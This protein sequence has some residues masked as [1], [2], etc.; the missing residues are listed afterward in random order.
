M[1]GRLSLA[2]FLLLLFNPLS[3]LARDLTSQELTVTRAG[4]EL[5]AF[6][7]PSNSMTNTDMLFSPSVSRRFYEIAYEMAHSDVKGPELEQAIMFLM[8]AMKLDNNA[9]AVRPLLIELASRDIERD[10]SS[11]VYNLLL[12]Y[13]DEFADLEIVQ[14]GVN[15]LL[16]RLDSREER[17]QMLE[18]MMGTIAN[19]NTVVGSELATLLGILKA[20]KPDLEAAEFYLVQAYKNNR[21]NKLAFAKLAELAPEQIEPALYLERLRLALRENPVN[22]EAAIAFAQRAEELQ[23]YDTAASAY[24][25]CADLFSYLYPSEILPARIYLPWMISCYNTQTSQSKCVQIAARIRQTGRFD[26]RMEAI[27]GRAAVKVGDGQLATQIIQDAEQKARKILMRNQEPN[28]DNAAES[29]GG[30][31]QVDAAQ[32]A[33]FYCFVIPIPDRALDWANKAF[34]AEQ[35]SPM[36]A[37]LLAYALVMNNEIETAKPL[38]KRFE[39]NQIS[40]LTLAIIQLAE[41]QNAQAIESLQTAISRDPGSFAAER[42]K[43]ILSQQGR[44]Y[45]PPI[46]PAS[47]LTVLQNNFGQSLVPDFIPPEQIVS[48][49]FNIRGD[50][51]TYG[52]D[53]EGVVAVVNNSPEPL[54]VDDNGLFKGNIRIDVEISGDLGKRIPNLISKR[55][56]TTLLI[57]PG[58]RMLIPVSLATGEL[59][60][61]LLSHP[62]ASLNLQFTAYLD[63]VRT[64]DGGIVNR[65]TYIAPVQVRVQRPGVQLTSDY[66]RNQFTLVSEGQT[67]QK[68]QAARLFTGL[69]LEQHIMSDRRLAYKYVYAD[70]MPKLL[71]DALTHESGLLLNSA[72]GQWV[73]KIQ[74]MADM[75][76]L[77]LGH[78][79]IKAVA[80]NLYANEWAVRMM[81]VY[82]L[83]KNPHNGFD[84]VLEWVAKNDKNQSVRD[85]AA[86]LSGSLPGQSPSYSFESLGVHNEPLR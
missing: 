53:I 49:E 67:H 28:A 83:A 78:K 61:I 1:H 31:Q 6:N 64:E 41:G 43:E 68:I 10:Y 19:N 77:P 38:I 15:Y 18:Q 26:L 63:P 21:Y 76:P 84:K 36:A 40:D 85:M 46:D 3:V 79:L 72:Q 52:S 71:T 51:F 60:N 7:Y 32:L 33:W 65:L 5:S 69:L 57:Q 47:L 81:A 4:A 22:I 42:A 82:L 86:S 80:E 50:N 58:R 70:W 24:G 56:R 45:V 9:V 35:N 11:L 66:L 12:Q 37:S 17:E 20:E 8:A 39:H 73:V 55:T 44:K 48:C 29:G 2:V 27:A 16:G 59:G 75:L 54:V 25:Y 34:V 23:L 14:K 62:Q 30:S 13:V 74:T